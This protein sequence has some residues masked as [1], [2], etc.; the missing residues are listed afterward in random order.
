M[1]FGKEKKKQHRSYNPL[2]VTIIT[3]VTIT[4][5]V[6]TQLKLNFSH[7]FDC[8]K[9]DQVASVESRSVL[10]VEVAKV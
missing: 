8:S 5:K 4:Y 7:C 9:V 1:H 3:M 10:G 2:S 6:E